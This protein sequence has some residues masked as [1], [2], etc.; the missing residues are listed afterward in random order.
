MQLNIAIQHVFSQLSTTLQLLTQVHYS[1][2]CPA[3]SQATIGQHT[4]HII[5]MF[6]CLLLGYETGIINYEKRQRNKSIETDRLFAMEKLNEISAALSRE[7][8]ELLMEASYR[9]DTDEMISLQTNFYREIA[10]NLEHTIHHMAL[11]KVGVLQLTD[12]ELPAGFGVASSTTKF[13]QACAR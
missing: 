9:E 2:P 7:N 13:K 4:R 8:K 11:I 6:Q 5:E 1:Q 10:Y 12:L 3:L